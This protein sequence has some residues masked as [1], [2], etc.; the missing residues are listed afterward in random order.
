VFPH[1]PA[2]PPV[3]TPPATDAA[4]APVP[5]LLRVRRVLV[6]GVMGGVCLTAL[7]LLGHELRTGTAWVIQ[8]VE[9][10][11]NVVA[12]KEA[13]RHLAD[14][15]VGT[16]LL[17]ADLGRVVRGVNEHPRVRRT[18]ARR[19]FPSVVQ[20][21]VEEYDTALL[22]ALDSLW[23]VDSAG[24]VF[25]RARSD[26]LD[27]PVLTGLDT[28]LV[29]AHPEVARV[30]LRDALG[31]L[32]AAEGHPIADP[33]RISELRLDR[34]A[35]F[36][37]I[38]RDGSELFFGFGSPQERLDRLDRLIAA[39]LHLNDGPLRVDLDD[40]ELALVRPMV[41]PPTAAELAAA[42]AEAL[43]LANPGAAAPTDPASPL[44]A[45]PH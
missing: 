43:A 37:L 40:A 17:A 19:L 8:S 39:G 18:E 14:L 13:I 29:T 12:S 36:T 4:S 11:G 28:S 38:L 5:L 22:L 25:A 45:A 3:S 10:S 31:I 30:A 24:V 16:P 7:G 35:G 27:H 32:A 23:T 34:Q 1:R 21:V 9:V 2:V 26:D 15:R 41:D 33:R 6:A 44:T 20:I 42:E